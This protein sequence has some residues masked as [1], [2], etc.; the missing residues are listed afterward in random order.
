MSGDAP[1]AGVAFWGRRPFTWVGFAVIVIA[2]PLVGFALESGRSFTELLPTVNACLNATSAAFLFAGWRAIKN[3]NVAL[4]WR[5]MLSATASSVL[6]LT[7]YLIRFALTGVHSYPASDWTR[8]AYFVILGSHTMLAV[9]VP[10]LAG[11][12][13]Y[14]AARRR[15]V[16]HRRLARW[17]FPIWM[18]V[19]VTGVIVYA[20][21]Y[22]LARLR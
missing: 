11:G 3:R 17:T 15:F 22:H 12:T 2:I 18:Y 7:F 16:A 10:F 4:H 19:S 8:T 5:C 6:F 9:T 1:A 14:L 20:M 21:L 13:L